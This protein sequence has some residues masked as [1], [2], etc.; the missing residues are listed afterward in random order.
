MTLSYTWGDAH[1]E[2]GILVDNERIPITVNL[3]NAL[4]HIRQLHEPVTIW[5]CINQEDHEERVSQVAFMDKVYSKC[6]GVYIWLGCDDPS[7]T[8]P[9]RDPFAFVRH[10]RDDRHYFELP[11]FYR[12]KKGHWAFNDDDADTWTDMELIS[13]SPWWTRAWTVQET[14]LPPR[15]GGWSCMRT[16]PSLGRTWLRTPSTAA[17]T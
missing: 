16:G 1:F 4:Q 7:S 3:H 17:T 9:R 10:F 15:G 11:G 13:M 5:V 6:E 12:D 2:K 8:R 14:M